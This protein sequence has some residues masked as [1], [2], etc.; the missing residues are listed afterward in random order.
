MLRSSKDRVV[1]PSH[2]LF[3][4]TVETST[5][6]HLS[7]TAT[8]LQRPHLYN[9]YLA[10]KAT[11]LKRQPLYNDHLSLQ[12]PPLYN[13]YLPTTTFIKGH[14]STTASSIQRPP[15]YHGCLSQSFFVQLLQTLELSYSKP[16]HNGHLDN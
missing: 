6:G 15:V 3:I 9:G 11:S 10:T 14:L 13:S 1:L 7:T 12:R 4:Y 2:T 16:H 5:N 8:S